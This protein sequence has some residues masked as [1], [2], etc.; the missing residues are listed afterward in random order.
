MMDKTVKFNRLE[1]QLFQDCKLL[2]MQQ[3]DKL[4]KEI[5]S[6][7]DKRIQYLMRVEKNSQNEAYRQIIDE[8]NKSISLCETAI[9][10]SLEMIACCIAPMGLNNLDRA[11]EYVLKVREVN[12]FK[13]AY[14]RVKTNLEIKI[15][16]RFS[17]PANPYQIH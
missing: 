13:K 17:R 3:I 11:E 10:V 14:D 8:V 7:I 4:E 16:G 5:Q 1:K 2:D 15:E 6:E 9:S 12:E